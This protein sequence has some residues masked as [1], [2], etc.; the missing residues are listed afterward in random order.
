MFITYPE[1]DNLS[2]CGVGVGWQVQANAGKASPTEPCCTDACRL[3]TDKRRMRVP[4]GAWRTGAGRAGADKRRKGAAG[5]DEGRHERPCL[6]RRWLTM[7]SCTP[8][9]SIQPQ[10]IGAM[11]PHGS[12]APDPDAFP[13]MVF[14]LSVELQR[15]H[16]SPTAL[17]A[18]VQHAVVQSPTVLG[19]GPRPIR[20]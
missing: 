10:L 1:V 8:S 16:A 14:I 17:P 11:L 20:Y 12:N 9:A 5:N 2:A 15:V 4:D 6:R 7:R 19:I 3:G 18:A 13:P